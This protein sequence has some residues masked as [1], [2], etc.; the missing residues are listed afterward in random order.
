MKMYR[1]WWWIKD[2]CELRYL[3]D[4]PSALPYRELPYF[5]YVWFLLLW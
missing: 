5:L 2:K 3:Q 4:L 1:D